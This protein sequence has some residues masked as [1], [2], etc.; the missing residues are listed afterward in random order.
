[1]FEKL[2]LRGVVRSEFI[3]VGGEP[4][5]LE[6]NTCPGLSAASIVPQQAKAMGMELPEFFG[7]LVRQA[8]EAK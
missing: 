6:V 8:L 3:I 2:N 1:M 4:H 5:F 7:C